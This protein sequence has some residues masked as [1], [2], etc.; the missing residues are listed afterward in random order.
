MRDTNQYVMTNDYF[1]FT[2]KTSLDVQLFF[3]VQSFDFE[4]VYVLI[5]FLQG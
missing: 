4:D 3:K 1:S 5:M 2:H